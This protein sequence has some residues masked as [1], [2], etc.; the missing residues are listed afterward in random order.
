MSF[1]SA[2]LRIAAF[3]R[4]AAARTAGEAG[5]FAPAVL[6]F[7]AGGLGLSVA[8]F[9]AFSAGQEE[10]LGKAAA[11][12]VV[13]AFMVA[14]PLLHLAGSYVLARASYAIAVRRFG[15][16]GDFRG[17]YSAMGTAAFLTLV[18]AIALIGALTGI[19]SITVALAGL[20][21]IA[22]VWFL[23]AAVY[24][25]S[26]ALGIPLKQAAASVLIPVGCALIPLLAVWILV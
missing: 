21:N 20:A 12:L 18:P 3:D 5:Y 1:L 19:H 4:S 24:A 13:L 25:T 7:S 8:F 11:V 14:G 6:S 23:A 26:G 10:P 16:H 22:E 17:Y 2:G 9:I 15:G